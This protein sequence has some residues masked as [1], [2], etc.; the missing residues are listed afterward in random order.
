MVNTLKEIGQK[1]CIPGEL[2]SYDV[3]TIGNI[4]G[5]YKVTYTQNDGNLKSY[6]TNYV[7]LFGTLQNAEVKNLNLLNVRGVVESADGEHALLEANGMK[8]PCINKNG[9]KPGSEA[10]LCVR[11]ERLHY[12]REAPQGFSVP[13]V[14]VE[15]EYAGGVQRAVIS[16]AGGQQ[17][18]AQRQAE[19][20]Q[21]CPAGTPVHAWWDIASAAL[22]PWE[23]QDEK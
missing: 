10:G 20:Q 15:H 22:V 21:D 11:V 4:N 19:N 13:G 17:L 12:A 9:L 6:E 7:A 14:V 1:F 2:R 18:T 23:A 8:L 3:I 5:T 16:L